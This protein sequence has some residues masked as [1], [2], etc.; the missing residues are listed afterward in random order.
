MHTLYF[1]SLLGTPAAARRRRK[2]KINAGSLFM[3]TTLSLR[4][5][6]LFFEPSHQ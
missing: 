5:W 6:G 1:R 4:R 3:K 2:N